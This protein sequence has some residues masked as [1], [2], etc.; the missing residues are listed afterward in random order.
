MGDKKIAEIFQEENFPTINVNTI[1]IRKLST[2]F[3]AISGQ[4][5]KVSSFKLCKL[6]RGI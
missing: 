4:W 6:T 2:T 3:R 1:L 5:H